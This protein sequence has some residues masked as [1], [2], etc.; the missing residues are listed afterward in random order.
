MEYGRSLIQYAS[1]LLEDSHVKTEQCSGRT[2]CGNRGRDW[3]YVANSQGTLKIDC[4]PPEARKRARKDTPTVFRGSMALLMPW[5][6]TSCLHNYQRINSCYSKLPGL[7]HFDITALENEYTFSLGTLKGNTLFKNNANFIA[8][9]E[10]IATVAV[11]W[12]RP[13]S[14]RSLI[15]KEEKSF[16]GNMFLNTVLQSAPYLIL[17]S[18][19]LRDFRHEKP[20]GQRLLPQGPLWVKWWSRTTHRALLTAFQQLWALWT[21]ILVHEEGMLP[22]EDSANIP[23]NF[24]LWLLPRR[25]RFLMP[26]TSRREEASASCQA[27]VTLLIRRDQGLCCT[28]VAGRIYLA[29]QWSTRVFW[30][31]PL[32]NF[33]NKWTS[34]ATSAWVQHGT[35][36]SDT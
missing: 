21:K 26:G 25:F 7:W 27:Y 23:L 5:F 19:R 9:V 10:C 31:S 20:V 34:A 24:K 12:T 14:Q 22:R 13:M 32:P 8:K 33:D 6:W 36:N 28:E 17:Y 1:I 16:E 3:N 29:S 15:L 35:T 4:K 30:G 2:P 11:G 18:L